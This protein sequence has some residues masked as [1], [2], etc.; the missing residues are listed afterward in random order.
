MTKPAKFEQSILALEKV[1]T[2]LEKGDV[3]LDDALKQFEK[4]IALTHTCQTLLTEAEQKIEHLIQQNT[5]KGSS[6]D[7]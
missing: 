7:A 1:V 6:T 5:I 4:G 2:A 3:S